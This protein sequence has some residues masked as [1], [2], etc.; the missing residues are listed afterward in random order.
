MASKGT[1]LLSLLKQTFGEFIE[2]DCPSMA[3]ALAYY[4]VFSLPALLVLVTLLLGTFVDTATIQREI[5]TQIETLIGPD[6]AEEVQV[7]V[8]EA[9]LS[10]EE[11]GTMGL[12]MGLGLLIFGATGAFAQLQHALNRAWQVAPDP[13]AG[14]LKNFIMKRVLS[15]GMVV[16]ISFLLLVSLVLSTLISALGGQ[17]APLLP[18]ALSGVFLRILNV[19][20]S[21]LLFGFLFGA[22]FKVLPDAEIGWRD[23]LVGAGVTA[24]L[25]VLGKFLIGL[26]LGQSD[27]GSAFGA[28]GSLALILVWIYYSSM[29]LLLGAEFTQVW[30]RRFGDRI[31]PSPGAVRVITKQKAVERPPEKAPSAPPTPG[32]HHV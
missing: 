3:A 4:T 9:S 20:V 26:Y 22:V 30:A 11:S 31:Q 14:G 29:I 5:T 18:D 12:L 32:P 25:F 16:S 1:T 6:A 15:L 19:L 7:M 13:E 24:A 8:E 27:P 28:A 21:L 17:L 2:D 23:V 10:T